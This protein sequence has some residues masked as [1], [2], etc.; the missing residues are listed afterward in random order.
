MDVGNR[1][2]PHI[3]ASLALLGNANDVKLL[4]TIAYVAGGAAG[5]HIVDITNP[6]LPRLLGSADTSDAR[7]V[8]VRGTL[9]FVA[10]GPGRL[11]IVDVS[12]PVVPSVIGSLGLGGSAN[13]VDVSDEFAVVAATTGVHI[14]DVSVPAQPR[15]TGSVALPDAALDTVVSDRIAY[16]A[17]YTGSLQVVDFTVPAT[18]V[19]IGSAPG[20]TGG[21]LW[22][23]VLS[24]QFILG[25]DVFFV[26]GVPIID[27]TTPANPRPRAILNFSQFRDDDGTGIAAD[28]SYV[29]VTTAHGIGAGNGVS[30]DTRLYIG[31]YRI[32]EDENGI[33]PVVGIV[34][35]S[36]GATF[37][38]GETIPITVQ[39]T[40]DVGVASVS[41]VV[42]GTIIETD[43]AP[44][45][46]FNVT[47]PVGATSLRLDAQAVD[48][49]NN[50]GT[51]LDV[52]VNIIP[53]PFTTV[54]GRV[55]TQGGSPA[56]GATVVCLGETSIELADG[57]FAVPHVQTV[58][59]TVSCRAT[60]VNG[61]VTLR[62]PSATVAPVRAGVTVI[63]DIVLA[64]VP[65]ID[66]IAPGVVD[67]TRPE[68]LVVAGKN[69]NGATFGFMPVLSPPLLTTGVPLVNAAGTAA[70]L[71]LAV[72]AS[73]R[74]RF[75]LVAT[76]ASGGADTTP[77]P[78]N[79]ITVFNG[80]DDVAAEP[81][82]VSVQPDT[83]T[84]VTGRV[85]DGNGNPVQGATVDLLSDG[86]RAEFFALAQPLVTLPDLTGRS[87]DRVTRATALNMRN[88]NGVFGLSS[89]IYLPAAQATSARTPDKRED[90]STNAAGPPRSRPSA[91]PARRPGCSARAISRCSRA[92]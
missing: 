43:A 7:D 4:G 79:T 87:P 14:V 60:L 37:V 28:G 24:G 54:A 71:P 91:I 46:Q 86:L 74:G 8:R 25:A 55:L 58:Q 63:G 53:D 13:G 38:E 5:L 9:A 10:D 23:V 45:Y 26:N 19:V 32:L 42:N 2:A 15:R 56:G 83:L 51:G 47:A 57:T 76:N 6:L 65:I 82:A 66:S 92:R 22:D 12:D 81:V 48:L 27:V 18:P 68:S 34:S 21:Y 69:L 75:T 41:L 11:Q 89:V 49:G 20:A 52:D 59:P 40:D 36:A 30:G 80:A 77:T 3:V 29:Y 67:A 39:A 73:A 64:P 33:P 78:G 16:V 61:A 85:V 50:S 44:P 72:V 1:A 90:R 62:G 17:D 70:T 31:Q 88:P 84:T 35:P